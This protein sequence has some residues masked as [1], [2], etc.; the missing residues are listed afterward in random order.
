MKMTPTPIWLALLLGAKCLCALAA[1]STAV[2]EVAPATAP[3]NNAQAAG[4]NGLAR[5]SLEEAL[6]AAAE[7]RDVALARGQLVAAQG[8]VQSADHA[9][10]PVLTLKS[11]QM[12]LQ[13]GLGPGNWLIEKRIDKSVGVDWTWERGDKRQL[14]TLAAQALATAAAA[15]VQETRIQQQILALNAFHDLHAAELRETEVRAIAD[16]AQQMAEVLR[17]RHAAGDLSRQDLSRAEIEAERARL[18]IGNAALDRQRAA[19]ALAS[20]LGRR[21]PKEALQLRTELIWPELDLQ[22][23]EP[24]STT[25]L[26]ETL[27]Q[28]PDMQAAQARVQ[29]AQAALDGAQALRKAD[30]TWGASI[31]HYPGT[32]TKQLELRLQMPLQVGYGQEGEIARARAQL[33]QA[34]ELLDKTQLLALA[35]LQQRWLEARAAALKADSQERELLPRARQVMAQ[36]ELAYAKG[37]LSMTDVLEA[38][39]SLRSS[40]L[41]AITARADYAKALGSWQLRAFA[42][43]P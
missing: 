17:K 12:D 34:H 28:R 2:P 40:L 7:N 6:R 33:Q 13:H 21:D 26:S 38:R 42:P 39:R 15:D 35:E 37:A 10:L 30:I 20:L 29:A 5:L 4:V 43:Q 1:P 25:D 14:R 18:D 32:S 41:D 8:D 31:D 11:S 3:T 16:S 19:L 27:A 23:W 24:S 36:A 22:H 9:P